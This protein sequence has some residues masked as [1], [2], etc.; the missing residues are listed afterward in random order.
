[1]F[2]ANIWQHGI[3]KLRKGTYQAKPS[4]LQTD[5]GQH[6]SRPHTPLPGVLT[7]GCSVKHAGLK[8]VSTIERD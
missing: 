3:Q 4:C 5:T 6:L 8:G 7:R 2:T 1:M